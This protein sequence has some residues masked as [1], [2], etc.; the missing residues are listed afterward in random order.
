MVSYQLPTSSILSLSSDLLPVSIQVR[1]RV[2]PELSIWRSLPKASHTY[3]ITWTK[4]QIRLRCVDVKFNPVVPSTPCRDFWIGCRF[5][6]VMR[7]TNRC[8]KWDEANVRRPDTLWM[9]GISTSFIG[10]SISHKTS[11]CEA[12]LCQWARNWGF[13]WSSNSQYLTRSAARLVYI[14]NSCNRS[15]R[16]SATTSPDI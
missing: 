5:L 4:S 6:R 10:A 3:S 7:G 16:S 14:R 15:Y 1:E 2:G 8:H 12:I 13:Y 9:G 11:L